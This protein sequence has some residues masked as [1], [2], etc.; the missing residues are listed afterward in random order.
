[1]GQ[2][3]MPQALSSSALISKVLDGFTKT[4]EEK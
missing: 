3:S 1:M 2:G 4:E